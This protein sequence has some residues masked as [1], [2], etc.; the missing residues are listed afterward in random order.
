MGHTLI[1]TKDP[2]HQNIR[3]SWQKKQFSGDTLFVFLRVMSYPNDVGMQSVGFNLE[4]DN[5]NK[6]DLP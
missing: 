1:H 4:S 6:A 3:N 2:L 5:A